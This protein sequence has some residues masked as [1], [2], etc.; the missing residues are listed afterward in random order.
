MQVEF[1]LSRNNPWEHR[2]PIVGLSNGPEKNGLFHHYAI[3]KL[4]SPRLKQIVAQAE[5]DH[6]RSHGYGLI[7]VQ[8]ANE[9]PY[10]LRVVQAKDEGI[11]HYY[12]GGKDIAVTDST[13]GILLSDG[14]KL[15]LNKPTT[16]KEIE[17]LLVLYG[18]IAQVPHQFICGTGIA[19]V[20]NEKTPKY[21]FAQANLGT[22]ERDMFYNYKELVRAC[23]KASGGISTQEFLSREVIRLSPFVHFQLS[24]VDL[25]RRWDAQDLVQGRFIPRETAMSQLSATS[26][27]YQSFVAMSLGIIK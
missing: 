15:W 5:T 6:D 8:A 18:Q 25:L 13:N 26:E 4:S 12:T 21:Y 17:K 16:E 10:P 9:L 22:I 14:M 2:R 24:S 3:A 1:P 27:N 19:V 20:G 11:R 7:V 23:S